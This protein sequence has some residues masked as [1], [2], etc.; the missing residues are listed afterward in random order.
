MKFEDYLAKH[1]DA[2]YNS[3]C[4]Y[5]PKD[6]PEAHYKM[7]REYV[8]R[9]GKYARPA[10]LLL[11]AELHGAKAEQALLPAAAMQ[12]SED[13]I[14]MHDDWADSNEL[15]RGKP[16]AHVLYGERYAINAGDALH[17]VQWKMAKDAAYK[18]GKPVG[19]RY[20]DKFYNI[21]W[22]TAWGQYLDMRLT[23]DVTDVTKFSLDDYYKSI[24]GKAGYYSVYGPMQM[25]AI[26]AGKDDAY[27]E[28]IKTTY[29]EVIGKAFQA[30]D[31]ILDCTSTEQELGKTIGND[32]LDGVKTAIL[33]HFVQNAKPADLEKVRALYTKNREAKTMEE[34]HEVLD[35]FKQYGSIAYAEQEVDRMAREAR[36]GFERHAAA[37]P[38]SEVKETARDAIRKMTERKK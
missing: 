31:D 28:G 11:W 13:W 9:R 24:S 20:Y 25:G 37:I 19:D 36:E 17:M 3:I 21:L 29:G 15:R 10:L 38:E 18:L 2:I 6:C 30:K 4:E 33:W 14:L 32:V 35:L 8:D 12:C 26:I 1:K 5:V 7:V 16:T 22:V 27:V 23:H 34:V